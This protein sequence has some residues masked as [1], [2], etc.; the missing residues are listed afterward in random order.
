MDNKLSVCLLNDSFPPL[1]DGVS[2]VVCNYAKII[3]EKYG[4]ALVATPNYPDVVD[5]YPF[6]VVRYPSLNTTKQ[7]GYRAGFPFSI[8]MVKEL[9]QYD[10]DIIHSHCPFASTT[11]AR[12]MRT[13]INVPVVMTYHTKFDIDIANA[14][15]LEVFQSAALKFM[16]ANIEACDEVWVVSRGSGENL[17]NLGYTGEFYVMD[18][19]VDFPRGKASQEELDEISNLH[20]LRGDVPVFL[21]VGRMMWYKGIRIILDGLSK[22]K[23]Q[24]MQFQMLFVGDGK[25]YDE[26]TKYA[27]TLGLSDDCIFTGAIRDRQKLRTYFSRADMFLFPSTFDNRP[28]VV[29]EAAACGLASMLI[30]GSSSAENATGGRNSMLIEENA[31]SLASAVS[32]LIKNPGLSKKLGQFAMDELY[33]S[34]DEAVSRAIARYEKVI[35]NYR[36]KNSNTHKGGRL[37]HLVSRYVK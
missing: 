34:W 26:I 21:F 31:D 33:L 9:G 8:N 18:N 27:N 25:D 7:V 20:G 3:Q 29:L 24:G 17:K 36:S 6:P 15:K 4:S 10:F 5:D 28:I 14:I 13:V 2:H 11:L 32:E 23:S 30:R 22:V 12:N 19:G 35:E 37:N 1:I 16:L